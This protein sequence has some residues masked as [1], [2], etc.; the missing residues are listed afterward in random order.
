VSKNELSW[1]EYEPLLLR[2]G[3]GGHPGHFLVG[4]VYDPGVATR[5]FNENRVPDVY[6][7]GGGIDKLGVGV[8]NAI[9]D[10]LMQV[11]I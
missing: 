6:V 5:A 11:S 4:Q 1:L 8:D 2:H 3:E 7:D 10:Q 9:F